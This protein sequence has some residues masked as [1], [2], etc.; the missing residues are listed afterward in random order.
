MFK[1]FALFFFVLICVW[2]GSILITTDPQKRMERSCSPIV[3]TGN[4]TAAGV[5]LVS[6]NLA[7]STRTG[8]EAAN[9][10]CMHIV[11]SVAYKDQWMKAEQLRQEI[12]LQQQ[13]NAREQSDAPSHKGPKH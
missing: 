9:Y 12:E 5:E 8:F 7:A 2:L 3:L 10:A 1:P 6:E 11:W 4:V 13:A